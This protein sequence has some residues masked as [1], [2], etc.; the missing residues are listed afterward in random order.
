MQPIP[1]QETIQQILMRMKQTGTKEK[2][3]NDLRWTGFGSIARYFKEQSYV[4]YEQL[5]MFIQE[6]RKSFERREF[7]EWKW[8]VV[9]R[10]AELLKHFAQSQ[11]LDLKNL[12]P[13]DEKAHGPYQSIWASNPTQKQ[14]EDPQNI[15]A[16]CWQIKELLLQSGY[17]ERSVKHYI[18]EGLLLVL[19]CHKDNGLTHYSEELTKKL[20]NQKRL[21]FE[22]KVISRQI[23]QNIRK[24]QCF[25]EEITATGTLSFYKLS[26]WEQ[27]NPNKEFA[28]HLNNFINDSLKEYRFSLGT[29]KTTASAVRNFL[30]ALE[31]L[32]FRS[33]AKVTERDIGQAITKVCERRHSA[34]SAFIFGV[35]T[36]LIYL[37]ENSYTK[38]DLS[39]AIPERII[40]K[41]RYRQGF[42][43][44][45]IRKILSV[46]DRK[47]G[48]GKRN[49]AIMLLAA[50]TGLRGCDIANLKRENI[51]WRMQKIQIIQQKTNK[52]LTLP[53]PTEAG[54][55]IADYLLNGRPQSNLPYLFLCQT[56]IIHSLDG[57]SIS[58]IGAKALLKSGIMSD[59]PRRGFHSFRR[60]FGT[61]LLQNE[62]PLD[63]LQQLL[64]H[65]NTDSVKP[66]LSVDES[67]LKKC[68]LDM[69]PNKKAGEQI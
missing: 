55:A 32:G 54:N 56:G 14:L 7:S 41:K 40:Q 57:R 33:F 2:R 17:K 1:L 59:I 30:F 20:V 9:R 28:K 4:T 43:A 11:N 38:Q 68:A 26:N 25:L 31:D 3:L 35:K 63:M 29:I 24:A 62:I 13:W 61:R 10:S 23:F 42:T 36:F 22:Q 34:N 8:K 6:Q 58:A 69:I 45:E 49:Y 48:L 27:R 60:S 12:V 67:G 50:Q 37:Y 46:C 15:F 52:P 39:K 47:T 64:G 21:E 65:T 16:L 66:Y 18:F 5:E 51:N 19:R 44:E 53:L